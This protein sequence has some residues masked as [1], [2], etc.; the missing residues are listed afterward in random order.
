MALAGLQGLQARLAGHETTPLALS[1]TWYLL[2]RHPDV[3]AKLAG[4]LRDVLR[5]VRSLLRRV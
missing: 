1:W 2:S 3:D 5:G 4:E